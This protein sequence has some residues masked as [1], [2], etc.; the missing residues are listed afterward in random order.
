[1]VIYTFIYMKILAIETSCDETALALVTAAGGLKKPAFKISAEII[2]SQIA[3]HRPFGGVVPNLAKR[4][5]LKNLPI[6]YGQIFENSKSEIQSLKKNDLI[7]VTVGPGLEPALWTGINFAQELGQKLNLLVVGV[8]HLE[9]HI[10]SNWLNHKSQTTNYKSQIIRFPAICL[11]VSGGHTILLLMTAI[12][13]WKKLGETRDDA[14]GEAFDK[15]AKMLD[16]PYPGGP[17]VERLAR[18]VSKDYISFPRPMFNEKNYDFS[19]S[20]LKTA[21][22]YY[23]RD[24]QKDFSSTQFLSDQ[25]KIDKTNDKKIGLEKEKICF[26]FQWAAIEVLTAKTLRAAEEFKAESILL[27]G[28]VA[29]NQVLQ[30]TFR[31]KIK[32]RGLKI[33]F[34]VPALKYNTDNAVMIAAAAYFN[35]FS[36]K[37]YALEAQGNL[38]L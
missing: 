25:T 27:C 7:A 37:K 9:G 8:N 32:E 24:R 13:R 31:S 12:D 33:N 11:I 14:V 2:A 18:S 34:H 3:V 22:L 15:V 23:I 1:M 16:L 21:V 29:A 5:H 28:G 35:S 38:S 36:E 4:E 6:L 17:E 20:G 26:S 10:Y 19:F 30:E